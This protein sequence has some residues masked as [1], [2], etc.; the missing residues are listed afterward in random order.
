[1]DLLPPLHEAWSYLAC[2]A[3]GGCVIVA[4]VTL[5]SANSRRVLL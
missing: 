2:T 4:G 1:V 3:V 5:G